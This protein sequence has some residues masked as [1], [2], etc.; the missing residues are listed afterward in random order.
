MNQAVTNA[1]SAYLGGK[2]LQKFRLRW[3]LYGAAAY[4][5]LRYMSRHGIM[6]PQADA[7]LNV[8]D[9]G[10]GMAKQRVGL[11][12][13]TSASSVQDIPTTH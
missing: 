8:I 10:L 1:T 3:L 4:Y 2:F 11:G 9:K 12:H 5:G 6:K 7:A 13:T